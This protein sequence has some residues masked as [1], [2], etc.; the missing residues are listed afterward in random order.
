MK[1]YLL[2]GGDS[3][4]RTLQLTDELPRIDLHK[5]VEV[6]AHWSSREQ[7]NKPVARSERFDTYRLQPLHNGKERIEVYC[8]EGLNPI[9][10]LLKGYHPIVKGPY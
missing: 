3:A 9:D 5:R 4:G 8:L 1:K 7:A 10:E 6:E 2:I